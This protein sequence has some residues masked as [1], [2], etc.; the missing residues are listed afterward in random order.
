MQKGIRDTKKVKK[1][2]K[3]QKN[4]LKNYNLD[5]EKKLMSFINVPQGLHLCRHPL[6]L[7][8]QELE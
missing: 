8:K 2:I 3:K 6:K 5:C 7:Q 1:K 4:L